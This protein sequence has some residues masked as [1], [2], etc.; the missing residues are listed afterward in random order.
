VTEEVASVN[1]QNA[2]V[3]NAFMEVQVRQLPLQTRN[4]V[5]LLS[6][7]PGVTQNG[8]V[9]GAKRDQNNVTLDGVDV[10]DQ[11]SAGMTA[12]LRRD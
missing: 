7:Q 5:E 6:L 2:T 12:P 9:L 3:G 8:E 11:Q 10:N 4:V 1:T